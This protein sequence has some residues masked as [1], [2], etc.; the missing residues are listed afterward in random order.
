MEPGVLRQPP[1]GGARSR[2]SGG[3]LGGQ[4][5]QEQGPAEEGCGAASDH[6]G[7]GSQAAALRWRPLLYCAAALLLCCL[8]VSPV[9]VPA[10]VRAADSAGQAEARVLRAQLAESRAE[11]GRWHA[12]LLKV[13]ENK[14]AEE[15]QSDCRWEHASY[16]PS[17]WERQWAANIEVWQ[18]PNG[19]YDGTDLWLL[20]CSKLREA[21]KELSEHARGMALRAAAAVPLLPRA[22]ETPL[23]FSVFRRR[24]TC[25][26]AERAVPIEPLVSFLRHP[27]AVCAE[28]QYLIPKERSGRCI[29]GGF[30]CLTFSKEFLLLPWGNE[31]DTGRRF[32]FDVGA[33]TYDAGPGGASQKWFVETFSQRG[34]DFDRIL[35]WEATPIPPAKYWARVPHWLRPRLQWYNVPINTSAGSG[36]NPLEY[37]RALCRPGDYVV[38][39]LDIDNPAVEESF[40]EQLVADKG[41]HVLVDEFLWEH[42]VRQHPMMWP[43]GWGK[44][45]NA[46]VRS[47]MADSYRIFGKLRQFGIR[48]HSWV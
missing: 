27:R 43:G 11:A 24:N 33:S 21:G 41:L 48:A 47:S 20:G 40:V 36:S 17:S 30:R 22:G 9:A 23:V 6:A 42:H 3:R 34:L 1:S 13:K 5:Q 10:A 25:T 2:G 45:T 29:R 15:V 28:P 12:A 16:E 35:A 4:A 8:G 18:G 7:Q 31:T 37:I 32:L 38:V 44:D 26:G 39:K 14:R 46:A 19:P